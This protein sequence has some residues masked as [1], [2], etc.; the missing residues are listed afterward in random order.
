MDGWIGEMM[1]EIHI[2]TYIYVYII[3][4]ITIFNLGVTGVIISPQFKSR[5]FVL[6]SLV[7][8]IRIQYSGFSIQNS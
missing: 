3:N 6:D 8:R 2:Y 4:I 5:K 1:L 7:F